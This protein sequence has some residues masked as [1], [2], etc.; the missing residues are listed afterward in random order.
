MNRPTIPALLL[1]FLA[2][3]FTAAAQTKAPPKPGIPGTQTLFATLHPSATFKT[4]A[5]ADWVLVTSDA[6]WVAGSK[7]WSLQRINPATNKIVATIALPGE[8]C[9]G[10]AFG[11]GSVW[12]PVCGA[13]PQLI[14]VSARTNHIAATLPITPSGPEGGITTSRDSVWLVTDKTGTTLSR[15]NPATNAVRQNIAIPAG[16]FN[17]LYAGGIVWITGHDKGLLTAVDAAS[18]KLLASISVGP[19]PRFLTAGGGAVWTLNQGDGSLT[20]VDIGTR[21]ATATVLLGIPGEGGDIDYGADSIWATTMDLP[22]TRVDARTHHVRR[23]WVGQGGDS[24]RFGFGSLW[25]TDYHR[26]LLWRIPAQSL[27]KP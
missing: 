17:P 19:K 20:R 11:F 4:G 12:A 18:G 13:Q 5:T 2:V 14:R 22:I 23:Q 6:V 21:K 27:L 8:A 1:L 9:T 24:L 10:L 25:L 7:P 26:G 15:I 3:P 16:S